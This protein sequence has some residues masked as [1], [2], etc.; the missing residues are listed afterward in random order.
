M[1]IPII[2]LRVGVPSLHRPHG[3]LYTIICVALFRDIILNIPTIVGDVPSDNSAQGTFESAAAPVRV[4]VTASPDD[5]AKTLGSG[6]ENRI[7]RNWDCHGD[8]S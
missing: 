1:Q 4:T 8:K 6:L 2:P 5:V 3:W 7:D